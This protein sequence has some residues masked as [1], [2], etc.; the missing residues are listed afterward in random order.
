MAD[1]LWWR[2]RGSVYLRMQSMEE[3]DAEGS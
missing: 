3:E 2:Y 1:N